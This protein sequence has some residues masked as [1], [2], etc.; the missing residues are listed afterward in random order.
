[1]YVCPRFNLGD[2][3]R[4]NSCGT[5]LFSTT[6]SQ[7]MVIGI[8]FVTLWSRRKGRGFTGICIVYPDVSQLNVMVMAAKHLKFGNEI[9]IPKSRTPRLY[10][11]Y[12][13][14]AFFFFFK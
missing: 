7:Q 3:K 1:M 13:F 2:T 8:I 10:C 6:S 4:P 14:I 9:N 12:I 5:F 11:K